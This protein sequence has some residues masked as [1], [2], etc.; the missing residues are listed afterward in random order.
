MDLDVFRLGQ[1]VLERPRFTCPGDWRSL[2]V[3]TGEWDAFNEI[4][5]RK[6]KAIQVHLG[7]LQ[8]KVWDEDRALDRRL[9]ELLADWDKNKPIGGEV[10]P[11]E[12]TN[13]LC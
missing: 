6:D 12:A 2:D 1:Q 8:T 11:E 7:P 13:A 4:L 10:N 3:L 9:T 5:T